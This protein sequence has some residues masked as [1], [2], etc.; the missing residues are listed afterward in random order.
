MSLLLTLTTLPALAQFSGGGPL[1]FYADVQLVEVLDGHG[2][3]VGLVILPLTDGPQ[4]HAAGT[5]EWSLTHAFLRDM[6]LHD[7]WALAELGV[8]SWEDPKAGLALEGPEAWFAND[9]RFLGECKNDDV[10]GFSLPG[11][12][13]WGPMGTP[14]EVTFQSDEGVAV[15]FDSAGPEG[16]PT[17]MQWLRPSVGI[18]VLEP[19][20]LVTFE[21]L[22]TG[23]V[24]GRWVSWT[25]V[26]APGGG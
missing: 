6:D 11:D 3:P 25:G 20:E 16:K 12:V 5:A 23:G 9:P 4:G 10:L 26:I 17:S 14:L 22:P 15:S 24:P 2:H 7:R 13:N 21:R 8:W 19:G 18:L 1:G